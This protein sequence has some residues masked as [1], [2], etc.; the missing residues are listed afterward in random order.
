MPLSTAVPVGRTV[1]AARADLAAL[2]DTLARADVAALEAFAP[3]LAGH[4]HA[5]ARLSGDTTT[6]IPAE[7][8]GAAADARWHLERARR[9]GVSLVPFPSPAADTASVPTYLPSGVATV[10]THGHSS[11][12][13]TG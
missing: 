9:L 10:L 6:A 5:L 7:L 2:A 11:L 1:E 3:I 13:V 4:A 8:A 12:E